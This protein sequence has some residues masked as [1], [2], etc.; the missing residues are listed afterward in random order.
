MSQLKGD[1]DRFVLAGNAVFTLH[2][3]ETGN[4]YTYRVRASEDGAVS[5]HGCR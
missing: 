2:N 3:T 5:L 1:L 4:R